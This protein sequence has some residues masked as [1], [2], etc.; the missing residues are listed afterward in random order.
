MLRDSDH[1]VEK[2]KEPEDN[3][4]LMDEI[5]NFKVSTHRLM[6]GYLIHVT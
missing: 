5:S 6:T 1:F 4:Y 2:E 3:K